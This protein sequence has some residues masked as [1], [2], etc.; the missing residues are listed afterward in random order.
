M[1][2]MILTKLCTS[3]AVIMISA[4]AEAA[5]QVI[6]APSFWANREYSKLMR[7]TPTDVAMPPTMVHVRQQPYM[8]YRIQLTE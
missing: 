2:H 3:D 5:S 7:T 6:T 4:V 1:W 8:K